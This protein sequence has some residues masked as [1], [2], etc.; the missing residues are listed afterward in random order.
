MAKP[1]YNDDTLLARWL[2]GELSA[3]E[4]TDLRQ[5]PEFKDYE[6]LLGNV[7]RMKPP[8]FDEAAEFSRLSAARTA[9][10]SEKLH[11]RARQK[12]NN[13][14]RKVWYAAA[15]S[16][17]LACM[18]WFLLRSP[19]RD[20]EVLN[21]AVSQFAEL[22]DGSMIKLNDGSTL[23]FV[24]TEEERLA[25]M[26]GEAY[27]EVEKSEVPFIVRTE[28]GQVTVVGTSFNVY[29]RAGRMA[30]SCTSGK[31]QVKFNAN[32]KAYLLTPGESVSI[33]T[34]GEVTESK[35]GAEHLDWLENRSVF[36]DRPL[37]E[38]LEEF[39]R[40]YDLE[41]VRTSKMDLDKTYDVTFPNDD[42]DLAL[43]NILNPLKYTTYNRDGDKVTLL[44]R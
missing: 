14:I 9:P 38:I 44:P 31:V 30:V 10:L 16:V 1:S 29:S 35:N 40:Q 41:V 8:E 12:K 20:F 23:L 13:S 42:L 18:A 39:E 5:R 33:Y 43:E 21:G 15:A 4:E 3:A 11:L 22:E 25:T 24:P 34:S 17:A 36:V 7:G 32:P 26:A 2:S 28:L 6:R 37:S 27:F 19:Q